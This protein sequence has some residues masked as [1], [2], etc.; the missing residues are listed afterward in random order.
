VRCGA[1]AAISPHQANPM[2]SEMFTL[3]NSGE[4]V[5]GLLGKGTREHLLNLMLGD[6]FSQASGPKNLNV[7]RKS[8]A[9]ATANSDNFLGLLNLVTHFSSHLIFKSPHHRPSHLEMHPHPRPL[10][11]LLS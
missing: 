6:V 5:T 2:G 11:G 10:S 9:L 7:P 8:D 1:V 4:T 3:E